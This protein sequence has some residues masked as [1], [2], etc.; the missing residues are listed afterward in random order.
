MSIYTGIG[1]ALC[2]PFDN[3]GAFNGT[4]YERLI[5]FQAEKGTD[6]I[7]SCGT[8]GEA[9]TLKI[10]EHIEVVRTAVLAA[11]KAGGKHGRKLPVIAGAGGNDTDDCISLGKSLQQA[12]ADALMYVTP[13]YNKTSQRGLVE[14]YTKIAASVDLPIVVY[15]VP[16][17]TGLNMQPKTLAQLAKLPNI[18]AVKEASNDINQIA[19]VFELC[20]DNLDVYVGNDSEI[21][22]TLALGG[23]GVISTMGNIAPDTIR[24]IV[25]AFFEGKLEESRKLQL[26][27][28]PMTRLLFTDVNPMPV[29]AALRMM[30]FD[31]G[32]CR[33]P[34]VDIEPELAGKLREAMKG[35]G[36]I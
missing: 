14:H 5:D 22:V 31:V 4:E 9:S 1:V 11:K 30:G 25:T 21:L 24:R 34:L 13:Y 23:K 16:S 15:N 10:D 35:F 33:L 19:E 29:K 2:T 8:T 18:Q 26:K 17:R 3:Q 6:A 32:Q 36:M 27:I 28:L 7:V 20:G 12:G